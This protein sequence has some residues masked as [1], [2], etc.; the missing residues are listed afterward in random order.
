MTIVNTSFH[1]YRP[2]QNEFIDWIR[3]TYK[4]SAEEAGLI[5]TRLAR[6]DFEPDPETISFAFSAES[7]NER[8]AKQ[9]NEGTAAQL[10][11][12]ISSRYGEKVL[13]FTTYME[14]VKL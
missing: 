1:I 3:L 8:T 9:W 5:H 7:D 14:E 10:R 2:I 13:F 12:D 11:H 6:I 4:T